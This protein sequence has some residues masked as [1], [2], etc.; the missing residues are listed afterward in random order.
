MSQR[1]A[2]DAPPATAAQPTPAPAET[3]A[4]VKAVPVPQAAP[5]SAAADVS[6]TTAPG[7]APAPV[8]RTAAAPI[9]FRE[10][11]ATSGTDAIGAL[12]MTVALLL[13]AGAAAWYARKRGWLDRWAATPA[14]A[15]AS[16]RRLAVT[17]TL[18]LSRATT[19][20]RIVDGAREYLVLES[21]GNARQL[22]AAPAA[23]ATP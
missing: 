6:A 12:G 7:V 14:G 19:V 8:A 20:Y 10:S 16:T 22:H 18:R 2:I 23:E 1:A 9:P 3:T 21:A 15:A 17:E 4:A 13:A 11:S 5:A